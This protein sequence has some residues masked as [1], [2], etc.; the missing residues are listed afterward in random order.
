MPNHRGARR[1][2]RGGRRAAACAAVPLAVLLAA[3]SACAGRQPDA[4]APDPASA[5][6]AAVLAD[7]A[8]GDSIFHGRVSGALCSVCHGQRGGGT[9]RGSRL[10]DTAWTHADGSL[11]SIVAVVARGIPGADTSAAPMLAHGGVRLTERQ[12]R[13]VATYVHR[14]SARR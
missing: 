7:A 2:V 6:R 8:L 9:A 14:L 4:R 5:S 3:F 10:S 12:V 11:A 13:A 1:D